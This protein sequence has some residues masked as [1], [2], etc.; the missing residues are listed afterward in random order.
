MS[1]DAPFLRQSLLDAAVEGDLDAVVH[2]LD[3]GGASIA[4][5]IDSVDAATGLTAL[6][7]SCM[8]GFV[9]IV[10]YLVRHGAAVGICD[11][12]RKT[13]LHHACH[14]GFTEVVYVLLDCVRVNVE[15]LYYM[16]EAKLTCLQTAA[17]RGHVTI[18][19][20]LL[21]HGDVVG[22]VNTEGETAL[23][24]AAQYDQVEAAKLLVSCGANIQHATFATGD[25]P[26]HYACRTGAIQVAVFL[27]SLG[28]S[29]HDLN[30]DVVAQSALQLARQQ[31]HSVL[32]NA[33]LEESK[34]VRET[35]SRRDTAIHNESLACFMSAKKAYLDSKASVKAMQVQVVRQRK[36]EEMEA[37]RAYLKAIRN[38][39]ADEHASTALAAFPRLQ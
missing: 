34:N 3:E 15:K 38:G 37:I 21:L 20:L 5:L 4:N 12:F 27:V 10:C 25:T 7:H 9:E 17:A 13:P 29:V 32:A 19:R 31:G 1:F 39:E 2:T 23:H 28:Q 26:L 8:R 18:V 35:R 16:N 11:H 6:H 33:I 14:F 24:L 30:T 36:L 22:G